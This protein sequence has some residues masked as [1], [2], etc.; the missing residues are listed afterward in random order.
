V[1]GV[2]LAAAL[3]GFTNPKAVQ[4]VTAALVQ[5]TNT[6]M[7]PVVT[8]GVGPQAGQ[9]VHLHCALGITGAVQYSNVVWCGLEDSSGRTATEAYV[10]PA[11]E[12][13]VVTSV[14][15]AAAQN[16]ATCS[17]F[18]HQDWMGLI[19]RA[20]TGTVEIWIVNNASVHDS[21][22][23]GIVVGPTL[24]VFMAQGGS[25]GGPTICNAGLDTDDLYGYLT[26]A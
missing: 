6:P 26:P 1:C 19:G 17:G 21:Y 9:I 24:N 11:N 16:S 20:T 14:D 23:S 4:A 22:P 8:Q 13:L 5:V 15:I 18:L 10:V 7:N 2:V 25:A 3:I 12:S